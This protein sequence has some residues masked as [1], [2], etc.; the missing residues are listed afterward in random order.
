MS[1]RITRG[2][3]TWLCAVAVTVS[4]LWRTTPPAAAQAGARSAPKPAVSAKAAAVAAATEEVLRET[5]EIRRLPVLR[6]VRSGAQ[7]RA[8]IERMLVRNLDEE[9]KP[10]ELRAG[11][12][13]LKKL[14]LLPADFHLRQFMVSVL[15]EQILGYYDPKT[16]QFYLADWIEFDGQQPVIAHELTHAL[17]DQHFDLLRFEHWRKGDADAELAA[18]AL[19]E[20]DATWLMTLYVLKDPRRLVGMMKSVGTTSTQKIDSAPRA[21]RES[22]VF[23][24]EQGMAWVRQLYT[25][26]GWKAVDAAFKDL[27]QSTEQ[28]MHAEKYFAHEAPVKVEVPDLSRALGAGWRRIAADVNG[29]WGYY[30]I[31]DQF[32]ND[33]KVS[34]AAAAGWGGDRYALY[35]NARTHETFLVQSTTWDTEQDAREFF[36][37]YCKRTQRRNGTQDDHACVKTTGDD[38]THVTSYTSEGRSTDITERLG[39]RVFILEGLPAKANPNTV[40]KLLRGAQ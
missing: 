35:E 28:I 24:Y 16:R 11:E 29:E 10:E 25:R 38:P 34:R 22:L 14:G 33:E 27:P 36:D 2:L 4:L 37:A 1:K 6:A 23:P 3:A 39:S 15:T 12:L 30:Q 19:V 7:S 31:L 40:L 26:G 17:Q 9:S 32:L 20:G 18:H 8:E 21:L 5:S 13:T